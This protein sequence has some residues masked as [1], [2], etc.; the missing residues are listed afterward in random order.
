MVTRIPNQRLV[1][2]HCASVFKGDRAQ[3]RK[4]KKVTEVLTRYRKSIKTLTNEFS[5][6]TIA[7]VA[8]ALLDREVFASEARAKLHFPELFQPSETQ[9]AEREASEAEAARIE[10]EAVQEA[11]VTSDEECEEE[12]LNTTTSQ[13]QGLPSHAAART[14]EGSAR[15][16]AA[17]QE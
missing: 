1:Y 16:V 8:K 10:A 3:I 6:A 9:E 17:E 5:L 2:L 15:D 4:L 12:L 11:I 13:G 7:P 14:I